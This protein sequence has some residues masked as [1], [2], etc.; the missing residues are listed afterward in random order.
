MKSLA[1]RLRQAL[2]TGEL[3]SN[4]EPADLARILCGVMNSLALRAR[5][6]VA[7]NARGHRG[8]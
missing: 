7:D 5:W 3:K 4:I 1:T 2:D 8:S 6:R